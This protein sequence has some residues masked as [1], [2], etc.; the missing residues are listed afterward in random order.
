MAGIAFKEVGEVVTASVMNPH[1]NQGS[2]GK[3][4]PVILVR[5]VGGHFEVMGLTT[6]PSYANDEPR[7]PVPDPAAIGLAPPSFFWGNR[8]TR[9]SRIDILNHVGW[10]DH[11]SIEAIRTLGIRMPKEAWEDLDRAAGSADG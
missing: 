2:R 10:I 7:T 4:R 9:V 5:E 3:S 8:L 6:S 1:E 11:A